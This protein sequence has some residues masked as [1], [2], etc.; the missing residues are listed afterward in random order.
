MLSGVGAMNSALPIGSL[1]ALGRRSGLGLRRLGVVLR[2]HQA[3]AV[4]VRG[5]ARRHDV[6]LSFGYAV[7]EKRVL[8]RVGAAQ[9]GLL[10]VLLPRL[11][12]ALDSDALTAGAQ[13]GGQ[14]HHLAGAG[15]GR[16]LLQHPG[17]RLHLCGGLPTGSAVTP[18]PRP[19][20]QHA[21]AAA[22]L[23]QLLDLVERQVSDHRDLATR[24]GV[25]RAASGRR[26]RHGRT[27][28]QRLALHEP[29]AVQVVLERQRRGA[30]DPDRDA[31]PVLA[32]HVVATTA[33]ASSLAFPSLPSSTR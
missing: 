1:C 20:V 21:H 14:R 4:A 16:R 23:G 31:V 18:C 33:Q 22:A 6:D 12:I 13:L 26:Q 7:G 15:R 32:R 17:A 19:K 9:G 5:L 27:L 29:H 11:G 2:S 8:D 30:A 10:L 25:G 3:H 28:V 24:H